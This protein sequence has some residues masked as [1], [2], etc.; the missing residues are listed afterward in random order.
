ML[1]CPW[2]NIQKGRGCWV[3]DIDSSWICISFRNLRLTLEFVFCAFIL[4]F[5]FRYGICILFLIDFAWC[6][7]T[8]SA[9]TLLKLCESLVGELLRVFLH[10]SFWFDRLHL[11]WCQWLV[12]C[13]PAAL[14]ASISLHPLHLPS[15]SYIRVMNC[16]K[17]SYVPIYCYPTIDATPWPRQVCG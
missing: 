3:G 6:Y 15:S 14:L 2:F 12:G 8:W 1:T 11:I 17:H 7:F 9:L 10:K 13:F 5:A 4:Q 16:F